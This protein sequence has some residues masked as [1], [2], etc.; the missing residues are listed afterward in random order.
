MK[1]RSVWVLLL[2]SVIVVGAWVLL[3]DKTAKSVGMEFRLISEGEFTRYSAAAL[4]TDPRLNREHSHEV[5]ISEPF[6][7]QTTEVTQGQWR[8]V[9]GTEPW[10][11]NSG[12]GRGDDH[13][14]IGASWHDAVAFCEKLSEEDGVTYRLPT[15]AEWEYACRAGTT[16]EWFFG[17]SES[18]L[19][20]YAW[21]DGNTSGKKHLHRVAQKRPNQYG[22]YDMYGN[23]SEW[24]SD[25]YVSEY[26]SDPRQTDPKGPKDGTIHVVRGGSYYAP[27]WLVGSSTR[28]RQIETSTD[29]FG[30][31]FRVVRETTSGMNPVYR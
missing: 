24:C 31:G 8:A 10:G 9:M 26:S 23:A 18:L 13:P 21:F 16:T 27:F 11:Y 6:Y 3:Q 12:S 15:E 4:G 14:V 17:D 5:V 22:L 7:M 1:K 29:T 20:E 28:G 25:V 19:F 2:L 30:L